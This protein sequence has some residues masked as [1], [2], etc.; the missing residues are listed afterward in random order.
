MRRRG[1]GGHATGP[2]LGRPAGTRRRHAHRPRDRVRALLR[3]PV[4]PPRRGRDHGH[5]RQDHD[6]LPARRDP[7][8]R[9]TDD[10]A[11]RHR[12]DADRGRARDPPARTTPGVARPAGAARA[13]C[14]TRASTRS[15]MEVSS[16][17]IDLHRVDGRPLRGGRVHEP[18]AGPPRLP[19]ARSRSTSRS[20]ARLFDGGLPVASRGR[21]HRRRVRASARRATPAAEWTVG[22]SRD[23]AVARGRRGADASSSSRFP[24]GRRR[25]VRLA[26]CLPLGRAT[27]T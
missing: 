10:R 11:D 2:R 4:R 17:A 14:S 19:R 27:S 23:A 9:R 6:G 15:R 21:Q 13:P 8:R 24:L 18:D 22:R 26:V 7:A 12:R 16:H 1:R 25:R 5:Q 20:S 3:R